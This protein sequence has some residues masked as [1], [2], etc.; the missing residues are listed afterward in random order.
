MN[1]TEYDSNWDPLLV[2]E[3]EWQRRHYFTVSDTKSKINDEGFARK[4]LPNILELKPSKDLNGV[5]N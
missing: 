1:S 3:S 4:T 2:S 5:R